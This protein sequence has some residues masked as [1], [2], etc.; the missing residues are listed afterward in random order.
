M[1]SL[2]NRAVVALVTL[3]IAGAGVFALFDLKRELIPSLQVP[4]AAVVATY[5]GTSPSVVYD[6]V[7]TTVE[8]AARAVDG[9]TEISSTTTSG[10]AMTLVSFDY[11]VNMDEANLKLQ[12]AL[13]RVQA[14][15]PSGVTTQVMTGSLDDYPI[16]QIGVTGMAGA[17]IDPAAIADTVSLILV[18]KLEDVANVRSVDLAGFAEESITIRLLTDAMAQYGVTTQQVLALLQN[19]G[20][21]IPAGTVAEG[22]QTVAVQLGSPVENIDQLRA[23]P[24]AYIP[25]VPGVTPEPTEEDP[26]PEPG[27]PTPA[28]TV[29]LSMIADVAFTPEA[30]TSFARLCH[31][32]F[33]EEDGCP[34]ALAIS[35]TKTPAGNTVDV[36][37]AVA[38][39]L[40]DARATLADYNL[41]ASV[42]YDQAPFISRSIETLGME[43]LLGLGACLVVILLFLLSLRS[44]LVSAVSI[45]LS[46]LAALVVMRLTGETLN[47]LTIGALT[48]A[49][50]RVV[51]DAIVVIENI[52]RHLSYGEE[53][54]PAI[55]AAVKEVG[56]AVAA[57]TICTVAVFAPIAF[58][59]GAVGEL[60]K[61]FA[62]TVAIAML[63]SL[64][65]ALT[66][67]PV[68]AYWFVK[69]PV[70]IDQADAER[71]RAE[72]EAKERRQILQRVYLATLRGSLRHPSIVFLL[73]LAVL[74]GTVWFGRG[75]ETNFLD[76]QGQDT[77]TVTMSFPPNTSLETQNEDAR[78]VERA[79]NRVDGI[80]TIATS[81]GGTNLAGLVG[82][83]SASVG[84]SLTLDEA[85]AADV[86]A[87][88]R[89]AL[90]GL[91]LTGEVSI[92][93]SA[94]ALFGSGTIDLLVQSDDP[95]RLASA[96]AMVENMAR[97][98]AGVADATDS[99]AAGESV[100]EV[101]IDRDKAIALGLTETQI[102][103]TVAAL[104]VPTT[105]GTI[106]DGSADITVKVAVGSAP[107]TSSDLMALPLGA[108][109]DGVVTLASVADL[110]TIQ[111]P[112]AITTTDGQ[113]TA[114]V[115]VTPSGQDLGA[116]TTQLE[117]EVAALGLPG[118]TVTVGGVAQMQADAFADLGLALLIAVAL[119]YIVMVAT[120]GSLLQPFLLLIAIPF[121]ATG[122]LAALL[123]FD[124]PLGVAPLVGLLMLVGIVVSNAIVLID[125]INQYRRDPGR[126][127]AEAI[128]DGARRRLR[129]ILMTA[130]ATVLALLPMALGVTGH[131]SMLSRPLAIVVIG[132]L[133]SSTLLTLVVVPVLYSFEARFHDWRSRRRDIRLTERRRR[134]A[135]Q[136]GLPAPAAVA[137]AAA[138]VAA[139]PAS[140]SPAPAGAVTPVSAPS[141]ATI[142]RHLTTATALPQP[143]DLTPLVPPLPDVTDTQTRLRAPLFLPEEIEGPST[144]E[145]LLSELHRLRQAE[146][147]ETTGSG[148]LRAPLFTEAE[149]TPSAPAA[150]PP[151]VSALL[152]SR[153]AAYAPGTSPLWAG[154]G[155]T[156]YAGTEAPP[157]APEPPAPEPEPV[158]PEP[159]VPEPVVP[160]P[161]PSE[162]FRL[163]PPLFS[164]VAPVVD[165]SLRPSPGKWPGVAPVRTVWPGDRAQSLWTEDAASVAPEVPPRPIHPAGGPRPD[166]FAAARPQGLSRDDRNELAL[167][168]AAPVG[169]VLP[170]LVGSGHAEPEPEPEAPASE[171]ALRLLAMIRGQLGPEA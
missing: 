64:L 159:V 11:G 39:V 65:V 50:G 38:A 17:S 148:R 51:D 83:G 7:T 58:V 33:P 134:R 118:V 133:I 85:K 4:M 32:P 23:L 60:F 56:G 121:A 165:P 161:A 59:S 55:I 104:A 154:P 141:P 82:G 53:K 160:E 54:R 98:L 27:P 95:D 124:Q 96:T 129:P 113:R 78:T 90:G 106:S 24:V 86:P 87:R 46:L 107:V 52:K 151:G 66:I 36:S 123:V 28:V 44:T 68:L 69:R 126:T 31:V 152:E 13:S 25:P 112:S 128:Q 119:V 35:I 149:M 97:G 167:S 131:S 37:A 132:G 22:A 14:Y 116:L 29:A 147:T 111:T 108:G 103:R 15:L 125:L 84:L 168:A 70:I 163:P 79:L 130:A 10:L 137:T 62:L 146:V 114:T 93:D 100:F 49:I 20:L 9:V 102:A 88:V 67:V 150:P 94:S 72:A 139:S 143:P 47:I 73:A 157:P 21:T 138:G 91:T 171:T 57:S 63:A 12:T 71:I 61:S 166:P 170:P 145:R 2:R 158:P 1:L 89:E 127:L 115:S 164:A 3:A 109:P 48:I 81:I 80:T 110:I 30:A 43:G 105:I 77:L 26:E 136:L 135:A 155:P 122:A 144:A 16:L 120:F 76:I 40:D 6:Q 19:N 18:P 5:T 101:R 117:A 99:L 42:V 153:T 34:D 45:P 75:L 41:E 74:G 8:A 140:P 169:P 92:P 142:Y 162:P 156:W